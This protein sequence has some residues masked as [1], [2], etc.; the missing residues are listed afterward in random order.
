LTDIKSGIS[1]NGPPGCQ[2]GKTDNDDE[3][4]GSSDDAEVK[5]VMPDKAGGD[6][7]RQGQ[8][9]SYDPQHGLNVYCS[10][11]IIDTLQPRRAVG[12]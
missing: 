1:T 9:D 4:D 12:F 7:R 5:Q 2:N 3:D 11:K 10:L 8:Q 6:H